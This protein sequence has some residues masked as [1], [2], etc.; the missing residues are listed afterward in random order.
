MAM[1]ANYNE[2]SP[3]AYGSPMARYVHRLA[4][5]LTDLMN[6]TEAER[7]V[8]NRQ[9]DEET[10]GGRNPDEDSIGITLL[11]GTLSALVENHK[12]DK[13]P[14]VAAK[15]LALTCAKIA[16]NGQLAGLLMIKAAP[17]AAQLADD[18]AEAKAQQARMPRHLN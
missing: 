12:P 15:A 9:L 11:A 8:L 1:I 3:N 5:L 10:N 7:M 14:E 16:P 13:V 4:G 17:M 18:V 2:A 6:E